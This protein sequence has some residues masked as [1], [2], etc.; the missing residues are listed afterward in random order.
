MSKDVNTAADVEKEAIV[1]ELLSMSHERVAEGD[2]QHA[3]ALVLDVIRMTQGEGA[4]MGILEQAKRKADIEFEKSREIAEIKAAREV[5]RTLVDGD[6][7]LAERGEED[8]LVDAFKDGSSLVCQ[9]CQ[10]L[11]ARSRAEQHLK[12]WCQESAT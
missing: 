7:I 9:R 11:I 8:I 5:C 1:A 4:I 6:T 2:G 3:L 12:Y 10:S